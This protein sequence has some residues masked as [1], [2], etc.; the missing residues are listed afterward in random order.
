MDKSYSSKIKTIEHINNVSDGLSIIIAELESRSLLHDISKLEPPEL[1]YFDKYTPMLKQLEYGSD[2]Y[3]QALKDLKPALDHHYKHNR[4]HPENH[5]NG[6]DGM[7]IVDIVEMFVDW[8]AA[9]KRT[10][11]GDIHK[12]IDISAKRFG[13]CPQLVN[14]LKNSI[15]II[16]D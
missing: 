12:S 13:I 1:E 2:E 8:Y 14:I 11:N 15:D 4:H 9:T 5:T 6:I 7:N 3:K 10:K 16:K